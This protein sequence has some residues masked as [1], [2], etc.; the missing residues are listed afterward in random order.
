MKNNYKILVLSDLKEDTNNIL[1]STISLAKIIHG[2]INFFHVKSA[3]DVIEKENQLSAIRTINSQY[4]TVHK[5]IHTLTK[6]I[7]ENYDVYINSKF[8]F[9]N[10][11]NE[12]DKYIQEYKPNIIVLGKRKSK[13]LNFIGNNITEYIL[14]TY[15]GVVMIASGK[16]ALEPNKEISLGM[17][18]SL[19][20][21]SNL[22][23]AKD[24]IEH[25]QKPLKSF[26][27]V[28]NS[29]DLEETQSFLDKK[30]IEYVFD[31]NDNSIKNISNY[32]S[33]NNINLMCINRNEKNNPNS[34]DIKE[35]ISKLNVSLLVSAKQEFALQ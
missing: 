27:I 14:K 3:T 29:N 4:K 11:K 17:L 35:V 18:N 10:V 30:M 8:S 5:K 13:S 1:K 22:K 25:T 34:L 28:Q 21:L 24:L 15:S 2:D 23:F 6:S 33:K 31:K 7:S 32:V 20:S 26:K 12:I 16:H 9:G 19:Q